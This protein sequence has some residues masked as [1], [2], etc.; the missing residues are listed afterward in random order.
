MACNIWVIFADVRYV[1]T[2]L[3][4]FVLPFG[5]Y[6]KHLHNQMHLNF[7]IFHWMGHVILQRVLVLR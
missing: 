5:G 2:R 1:L 4:A 7:T 3:L 6:T